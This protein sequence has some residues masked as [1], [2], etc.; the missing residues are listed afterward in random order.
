MS[1]NSTVTSVGVGESMSSDRRLWSSDRY[2]SNGT[3][4][5][6][7]VRPVLESLRDEIGETVC[8]ACLSGSDIVHLA[9]VPSR[10]P[11]QYRTDIGSR[12]PV[13]ATALGKA[14]LA[15]MDERRVDEVMG[16]PPYES[17]TANTLT[18]RSSLTEDLEATRSRGYSLDLEESMP[19]LRCIGV[20][21]R[22]PLIGDVAISV[23]ASSLSMTDE[24]IPTFAEAIL[25]TGQLLGTDS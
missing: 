19:G 4:C 20:A 24:R 15:R 2:T 25:R 13:H 3:A 10:H 11:I 21:L 1:F 8:F 22:K 14:I 12:A 16:D 6:D 23:S 7:V 18:D 9:V 5:S 17:F